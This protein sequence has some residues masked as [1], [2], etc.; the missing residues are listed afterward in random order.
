MYIYIY[1]RYEARRAKPRHLGRA[2]RSKKITPELAKKYSFECREHRQYRQIICANGGNLHKA[3]PHKTRTGVSLVFQNWAHSHS[4]I[5]LFSVQRRLARTTKT[6]IPKQLR[7]SL[8]LYND[9]GI[10]NAASL[11]SSDP[12]IHPVFIECREA[13]LQNIPVRNV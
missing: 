7:S 10:C 6:Y 3:D 13:F 12:A 4:L 9:M 1:M 11:S 8:V 2:S 5:C